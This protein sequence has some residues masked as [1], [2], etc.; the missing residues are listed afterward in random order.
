MNN[1]IFFGTI[2]LLLLSYNIDARPMA[3]MHEKTFEL[4]SHELSIQQPATCPG[5][6]TNNS[7]FTLLN[8]SNTTTNVTCSLCQFL[9]NVIDA[10]IKHGNNTINEIT[11]IIKNICSV[12]EG[13]SGNT[14]VLVVENIQKIIDWIT[15]GMTDSK[16]CY[17][18][19]LCNN[20][21][22]KIY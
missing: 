12:I 19:H 8:L 2:F 21:S 13:P 22:V 14:C 16:I 18:L 4:K 10:E 20:T 1:K 9:V 11:Q 6:L 7:N 17:Q 3:L 15:Q 5:D